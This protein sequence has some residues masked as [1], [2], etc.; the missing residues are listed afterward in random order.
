MFT[1][2]NVLLSLLEGFA[3]FVIM[4]PF[5]LIA[6][7]YIIG[8]SQLG[9]WLFFLVVL[10][11]AGVFYRAFFSKHPWWL[12]FIVSVGVG[13]LTGLLFFEDWKLTGPLMLMHTIFIYRGMMYPSSEQRPRIPIS[14][15]GVSG[16]GIYFVGYFIFRFVDVFR[17]YLSAVTAG[18]VILVAMTLFVANQ[19]RLKSVTLSKKKSPVVD[20]EIKNKNVI[21]MGLTLMVAFLLANAYVIQQGLWN[22]V[23]KAVQWFSGI[24][25]SPEGELEEDPSEG[26][27]EDPQL[28]FDDKESG[29]VAKFLGT[30]ATYAVYILI[31]VVIVLLV[32]L[33]MKKTRERIVRM[34]HAFIQF[35]KR[36][37]Y[38]KSDEEQ[39][40]AYTDEKENLFSWKEWKQERKQRAK[41]FFNRF[42]REPKWSSMS[43][44]QKV[45]FVYRKL[46]LSKKDHFDY[47]PGD[48]P[49]ETLMKL[50]S[51]VPM[52]EATVET[53]QQA[54]EKTRY[55]QDV[56]EDETTEEI[57]R[58]INK[59]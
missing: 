9:I 41:G 37:A 38:Q 56:V 47:R 58:L 53:L 25:S 23:K 54:Y 44:G 52:D 34:Y 10:M 49:K 13:F 4:F 43:N 28:P 21:F 20:Q 1:K 30:V 45:R 59:K 8:P 35:L 29:T 7:H 42:K 46:L 22:G 39:I 51:E 14:S 32:L 24:Q 27:Q 33:M 12:F 2:P 40:S 18:G 17:P 15:L 55:R 19:K 36:M 50:T 48:T 26:M 5:L 11:A 57:R 16:F 6:G 31:A 3:E